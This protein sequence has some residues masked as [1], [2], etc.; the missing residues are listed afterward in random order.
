[1]LGDMGDDIDVEVASPMMSEL[2]K[3][4]AGTP[5]QST[6]DHAEQGVALSSL[7]S[8]PPGVGRT[9]SGSFHL[10]SD[11]SPGSVRVNASS[12]ASAFLHHTNATAQVVP[13]ADVAVDN[14]GHRAALIIDAEDRIAELVQN[15]QSRRDALRQVARENMGAEVRESLTN[16]LRSG[17]FPGC[18]RACSMCC[19]ILVMLMVTSVLLFCVSICICCCAMHFAGW[20]LAWCVLGCEHQK[21]LRT[22]L[23]LYQVLSLLEPCLASLM[24][25][26]V[27]KATENIEAT[28]RP[29]ITRACS[30]GYAV[31]SLALK[32]FWCIHVQVLVAVAPHEDGCGQSLPRFMGWYSCVLLLQ[33]LIVEPFI[34]ISMSLVLRAAARGLL[35]TTRGAKSGT[36]EMMDAVDYDPELFADPDDPGDA[37]PQ[38]ECCFCLE[39][40]DKSTA[41]IRTPCQHFM[42]KECLTKWLCSSHCCPICRGDLEESNA[43]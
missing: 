22:W 33:L 1:M 37:R 20:L 10:M 11:Q 25:R 23:L 5:L 42:H 30:V 28:S 15:G 24:R 39:E 2:Q 14:S 29:R 18:L 32:V 31:L 7:L 38:K 43:A 40:Y 13:T 17:V 21:D 41:I 35:Q 3:N 4:G 9:L 6:A 12:P 36:I 19:G 8:L 16:T 34:R 26:V 27:M